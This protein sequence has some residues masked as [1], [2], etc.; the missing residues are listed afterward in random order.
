MTL[1]RQTES[2]GSRREKIKVLGTV[3]GMI[4]DVNKEVIKSKEG[5]YSHTAEWDYVG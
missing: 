3:R 5:G 2:L 4:T 1:D